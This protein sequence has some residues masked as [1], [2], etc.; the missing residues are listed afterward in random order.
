MNISRD[1]FNFVSGYYIGTGIGAGSILLL[2][3][4]ANK[5]TVDGQTHMA[6]EKLWL[7]YGPY[8]VKIF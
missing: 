6:T 8:V 3:L 5:I 4:Q 1:Y 2:L 7:A